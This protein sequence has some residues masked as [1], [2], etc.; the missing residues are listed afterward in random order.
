MGPEKNGNS[1]STQ[2]MKSFRNN[3]R[4]KQFFQWKENLF[5]G[6][7]SIVRKVKALR[8]TFER[9]FHYLCSKLSCYDTNQPKK[10]IERRPI[11]ALNNFM[12]RQS[13]SVRLEEKAK[14]T[15]QWLNWAHQTIRQIEIFLHSRA[16]S[17]WTRRKEKFNLKI[18]GRKRR[19]FVRLIHP[20]TMLAF[21]Y[22]L[23]IGFCG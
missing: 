5:E 22:Y 11:R 13:P 23:F 2:T 17:K 10:E 19:R 21:L 20:W 3:Q 18:K 6:I 16:N 9:S 7:S 8:S 12:L 15:P 1:D 4:Q 14:K